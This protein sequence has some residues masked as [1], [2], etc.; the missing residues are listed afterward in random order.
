[1][2]DSRTT[3]EKDLEPVIESAS[4]TTSPDNARS[5][6]AAY[7]VFVVVAAVLLVLVSGISSCASALS[8]AAWQSSS[9]YGHGWV[10][11]DYRDD[12]DW[13]DLLDELGDVDGGSS[14][15]YGASHAAGRAL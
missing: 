13:L 7:I 9:G 2:D 5:G 11:Y 3:A 10:E 1:M 8:D 12:D 6:N 15:L 4:A 14:P